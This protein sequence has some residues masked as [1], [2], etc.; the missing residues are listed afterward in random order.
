MLPLAEIPSLLSSPCIV[1]HV[2]SVH[3][4]SNVKWCATCFICNTC[5]VCSHGLQDVHV[6]WHGGL[7]QEGDSSGSCGLD[8]CGALPTSACIQP[9]HS[10]GLRSADAG[11]VCSRCR[12]GEFSV[13][14]TPP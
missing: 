5:D 12:M 3:P 10:R 8:G 2:Q 1:M 9:Q 7:I 13:Q 11:L 4:C 6:C 14:N